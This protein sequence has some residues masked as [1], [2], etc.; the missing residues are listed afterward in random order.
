MGNNDGGSGGAKGGASGGAV[1]LA[2]LDFSG[3]GY[4]GGKGYGGGSGGG[5]GGPPISEEDI[6]QLIEERNNAKN[7]REF[8]EADRVRDQLKARGVSIDDRARTW[9]TADGRSGRKKIHPSPS[10]PPPP[11]P[12]LSNITNKRNPQPSSTA[13]PTLDLS[14]HFHFASNP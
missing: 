4:G 1:G 5:G 12:G 11:H 3:G 8:D 9:S 13:L 10:L 14:A 2:P 7:R 6:L